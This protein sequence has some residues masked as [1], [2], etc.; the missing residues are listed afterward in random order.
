MLPNSKARSGCYTW[1]LHHFFCVHWGSPSKPESSRA[2]GWHVEDCHYP[3][4]AN[5]RC[6]SQLLVLCHGACVSCSDSDST[7][8]SE[9]AVASRTTLRW[10][11][12]YQCL[13]V[14]LLGTHLVLQSEMGISKIKNDEG[15]IFG[16]HILLSDLDP[17]G[18][19]VWIRNSSGVSWFHQKVQYC[20]F[21]F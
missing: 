8:E 12:W 10:L 1:R 4:T 18:R 17:T 3:S 5:H 7:P 19:R 11:A 14:R 9:L 21:Q 15:Q 16:N 6:S 2:K 20:E 13:Q